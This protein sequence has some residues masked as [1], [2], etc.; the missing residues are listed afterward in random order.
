MRLG[1][2]GRIGLAG[3]IAVARVLSSLLYQLSPWDPVTYAAVSLL[4]AGVALL[5][6]YLPARRAAK[7]DPMAA[8][9]YE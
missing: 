4:L 3:T 9:R 7:M 1:Q 8:L 2:S 5:A 6:G